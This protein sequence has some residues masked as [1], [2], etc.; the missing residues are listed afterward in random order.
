MLSRYPVSMVSQSVWTELHA[1]IHITLKQRRLLPIGARVLLA[2]SGGQDSRCLLQLLLD[3]QPQWSWELAIAH[4]DH[5]WQTDGGIAEFVQAIAAECQLPFYLATAEH[6]VA[7]EAAARAWRYQALTELARQ[8]GY[9]EVV[10][11]HTASDR[12]ETLLYN[13]V[14]GSG[15]D[16]LV[17]LTWQRSLAT[18]I[19]LVRPLLKVTRRQTA[20][21]CQTRSL[22]FWQDV[23]NQ[24]L[25]FARVRLRQEVIPQLQMY[26]NPQVEQTLAQTA[27]L[28]QADVEYLEGEASRLLARS[29]HPEALAL[30][31]TPLRQAPVALQRRALRQFLQTLLPTAP[32]YDHVEKLLRLLSAPNRSQTDPFPG[33]AI[34]QV[35]GEWIRWKPTTQ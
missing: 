9:S 8:H 5:R 12:A 32:S 17:A 4:C 14:R 21:F 22:T 2:V 11:G 33:G 10:T 6:A 30:L 18:G 29:Q 1:Q 24:D 25:R 34:A 31:L 13:L 15:M 35:D 26:L 19:T 20:E 23:A 16:G 7:S 27:E 28:L 3:L